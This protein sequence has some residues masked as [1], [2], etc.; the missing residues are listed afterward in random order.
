[1]RRAQNDFLSIIYRPVCIIILLFSLFGLVWLRSSV[2]SIAY[3]LRSLEEKK[4]AS[5]K[6]TK[7][8]L[9]D[10]SKVISLA[11]IGSPFQGRG[12]DQ[13]Q[14]QGTGDYKHVSSG[15]V[16][17]DRVKVIHVKR[18]TGPET[19]KASFEIKK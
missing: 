10:R 11:S 4:M 2:V 9:A 14:G 1:M 6:E 12:Q 13:S 7:M 16:F 8:L 18:H 17:P 15:Y 19:Y 3:D 5:Q